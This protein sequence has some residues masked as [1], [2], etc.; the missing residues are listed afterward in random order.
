M[1]HLFD[2][3]AAR[4][5]ELRNRIV[6]SPMCQYSAREDG[7]VTDWHFVHY[8]AR[9]VGGVGLVILEMSQV[10]PHGRLSPHDIGI[11]DDAQ[12]PGLR[13]IVDL[14]HAHGA[15]VGLQLG[16]AGRKADPVF[17]NVGPSPIAF[18]DRYRVPQALD[19][20]GVAQ[21][22]DQF[23]AAARRANE[24]GFD[25]VEIHG[26]HGYLLHQFLSPISNQ[27]EDAYGGDLGGR[28]RLMY[29]V[30][31]AIRNVF[32]HEKP[33]FARLSMLEAG[34]EG[35]YPLSD[36]L[37][38]SS[39]LHR[40]HGVDLIDCTT[41]GNAPVAEP[42]PPG[43]RL[44]LSAAVKAQGVPAMPVGRMEFPELAEAAVSSGQADLVALARGLLRD[45]HW[46]LNAQRAL[47][48]EITPP[49]QYRRAYR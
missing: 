21:V 25:M 29:E 5:L 1:P 39:R 15:A 22:V 20:H 37:E 24:A 35:G 47:H 32:A 34:A 12:V 11:W 10:A 48:L 42:E 31:D 9:A 45:P 38:V 43:F 2:P 26:A 3:Y 4:S 33:V 16:H 36:T 8:G 30:A 44:P 23:A 41:G 49:T 7:T 28:A 14:V 17:E 13:R 27:R 40:E 46:A 6:M 19:R 18:S